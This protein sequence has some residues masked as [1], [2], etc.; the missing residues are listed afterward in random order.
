VISISHGDRRQ[1][2]DEPAE[3]TGPRFHVVGKATDSLMIEF[4]IT[5]VCVTSGFVVG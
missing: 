4:D 5:P 2:A 1:T 3:R